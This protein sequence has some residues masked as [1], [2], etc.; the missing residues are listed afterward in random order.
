MKISTLV[1]MAFKKLIAI[2]SNVFTANN[3]ADLFKK[4][5]FQHQVC[6]A[7]TPNV[8]CNN[9]LTTTGNNI[10]S[11]DAPYSAASFSFIPGSDPSTMSHQP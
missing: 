5:G 4:E 3:D 6:I 11:N 7:Y 8:Y 10:I 2:V 1:V 9:T